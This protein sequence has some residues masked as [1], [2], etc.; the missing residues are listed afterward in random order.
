MGEQTWKCVCHNN[1][2]PTLFFLTSTSSYTSSHPSPPFFKTLSFTTQIWTTNW[3]NHHRFLFGCDVKDLSLSLP[4]SPFSVS[5]SFSLSWGNKLFFYLQCPF[6]PFLCF[7]LLFSIMGKQ[8]IFFIHNV[9]PEQKVPI[10]ME[11]RKKK[12]W[13]IIVVTH[14]FPGLFTHMLVFNTTPI[15]RPNFNSF[16]RS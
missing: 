16:C 10:P 14:T 8:V 2:I 4:S 1:D 11:V 3:M 12:S 7:Y 13:N 15:L 6:Q 9:T 5:I